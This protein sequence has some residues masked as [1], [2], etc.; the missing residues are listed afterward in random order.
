MEALN[1]TVTELDTLG[2]VIIVAI[3]NLENNPDKMEITPLDLALDAQRKITLNAYLDLLG[4]ANSG[5]D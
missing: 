3:K 1:R 4:F 5:D 2:V